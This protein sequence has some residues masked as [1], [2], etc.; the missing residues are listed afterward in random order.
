MKRIEMIQ[1]LSRRLH[2]KYGGDFSEMAEDCLCIIEKAGML[3][4]AKRLDIVTGNIV[5][6]Y[7][8]DSIERNDILTNYGEKTDYILED[9]SILWEPE[10]E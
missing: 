5:Y 6:Y 1:E 3:P 9:T 2:E 10:E 8:P 7:V 4:P